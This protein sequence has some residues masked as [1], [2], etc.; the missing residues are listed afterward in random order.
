MGERLATL[1]NFTISTCSSDDKIRE[2][3]Q[4]LE[5]RGGNMLSYIH[6]REVEGTASHYLRLGRPS[7]S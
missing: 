1:E 6:H 7:G 5:L 4:V 3:M 2:C